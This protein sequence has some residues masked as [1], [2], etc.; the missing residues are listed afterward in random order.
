VAVLDW[1]SH[2]YLECFFAVPM[3]GDLPHDGKSAGEVVVRAPWLTQ[4]Y[5]DDPRQSNSSGVAVIC[6]RATSG[7]WTRSGYLLITDRI[8]DML[9]SSGEWIS[10]LQIEDLLTQ[11]PGVREAAVIGVLRLLSGSTATGG[12]IGRHH[13]AWRGLRRPLSYCLRPNRQR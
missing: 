10:S 8:N 1:D 11:L 9:E 13:A 7:R 4:G 12:Q 2:R 6:T 3:M 5:F